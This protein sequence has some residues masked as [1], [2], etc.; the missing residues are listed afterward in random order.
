MADVIIGGGSGLVP[1]HILDEHSLR[2]QAHERL[3]VIGAEIQAA[4]DMGD[5]TKVR[6]LRAEKKNLER[7]QEQE[8]ETLLASVNA[9][10]ITPP[11]KGEEADLDNRAKRLELGRPARKTPRSTGR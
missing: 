10:Q 1:E 8:I 5:T 3:M 4:A 7:A 6:A 9:R 2:P 11:A